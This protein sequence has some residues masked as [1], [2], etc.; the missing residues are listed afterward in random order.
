MVMGLNLFFCHLFIII[1]IFNKFKYHS[2][3]MHKM[4]KK[5]CKTQV[6]SNFSEKK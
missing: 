6:N 5:N 1:I 3:M 2:S 4:I